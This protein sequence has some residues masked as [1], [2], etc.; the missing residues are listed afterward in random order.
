MLITT[1]L[2]CVAFAAAQEL[3]DIRISVWGHPR[4]LLIRLLDGKAML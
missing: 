2:S 1:T 4:P 3:A